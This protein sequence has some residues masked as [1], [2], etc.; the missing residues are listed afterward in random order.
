M[1]KM[2]AEAVPWRMSVFATAQ[3]RA[4]S[5]ECKTRA[6]G[7]PVAKKMSD[8]FGPQRMREELLAAKTPSVGRA[9][10]WVAF[11]NSVQCSPSSVWRMGNLLSMGSL[12]AKQ[13]FSVRQTSPSRKKAG[14]ESEYCVRQVLPA[15]EVL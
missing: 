5:G 11:G 9:V 2:P 12:M 6:G 7:A 4:W 15:S 8:L 3:V 13:S 10:G 1:E 14:R